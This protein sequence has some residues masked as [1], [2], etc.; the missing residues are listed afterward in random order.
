V[1]SLV[2]GAIVVSASLIYV[3]T[4]SFVDYWPPHG[5]LEVERTDNNVLTFTVTPVWGA[6]GAISFNNCAF[7]L[8][9][10]NRTAGPTDKVLGTNGYYGGLDVRMFEGAGTYNASVVTLGGISYI[11]TI[12]DVDGDD[13]LS[14]NDQIIIRATEPILEGTSYSLTVITEVSSSWSYGDLS[15]T[16]LEPPET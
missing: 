9:V 11:V 6:D 10:E 16:Y 5:S 8:E 14:N 3:T 13:H 1:I 4:L 7:I 15:G 2:V 12:H